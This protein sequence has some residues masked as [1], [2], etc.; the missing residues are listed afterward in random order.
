MKELTTTEAAERLGVAQVTVRLWCKQGR[1]PHA[2]LVE[3][4]RGDYWLIPPG[5]LNGVAP[6]K[7]G[8]VPKAKAAEQAPRRPRKKPEAKP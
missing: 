6:R 1:F 3:H 7:P 4:P 8:P 5:D 2:R